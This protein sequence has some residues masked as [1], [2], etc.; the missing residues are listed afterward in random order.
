MQLADIPPPK[1]NRTKHDCATIQ[2]VHVDEL[3]IGIE[4]S[5]SREWTRMNVE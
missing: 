1:R 2:R 4:T 3:K 5:I